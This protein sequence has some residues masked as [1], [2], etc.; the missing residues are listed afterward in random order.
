VR[1]FSTKTTAHA[2]T[3]PIVRNFIA[4]KRTQ[5]IAWERAIFADAAGIPKIQE[6]FLKTVKRY[7]H[8]NI[9]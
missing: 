4:E 7:T 9:P 8:Q 6:V 2:H 5:M 3:S 1:G